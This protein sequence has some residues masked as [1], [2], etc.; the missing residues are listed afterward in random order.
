MLIFG[1][2]AVVGLF[3]TKAGAEGGAIFAGI[4]A[5]IVVGGIFAY[6]LMSIVVTLVSAA[7]DHLVL[8]LVG[9]EPRSFEVTLRATALSHATGLLGLIPFCGA[10]VALVWT[11]ILRVFAYKEF[12][13]TTGGKAAAG[14]LLAPAVFLTLGVLGYIALVMFV[15]MMGA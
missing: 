14:A 7:L 9:A 11:V 15:A 8:R 2:V 1:V 10:Q 5:V 12:H 6:V 3:G 13:Q 4:A